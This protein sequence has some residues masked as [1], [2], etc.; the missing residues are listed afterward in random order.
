MSIQNTVERLHHLC[1]LIPPFLHNIGETDFSVK[2]G[3]CKWSKKQILGHL[4]DSATNNH[5]RFVRA[6]FEHIPV[7]HYDQDQWNKFSY[8]EYMKKA[9][10]IEMWKVYNRYLLEIIKRIPSHLLSNPCK[11]GGTEPVSLAFVIEDYVKHLEHHLRQI[12]SYR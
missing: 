8:H 7:I 3:P 9:D 10:L 5:Q 12:V 6:Q 4:I 1:N 11:T 2:P